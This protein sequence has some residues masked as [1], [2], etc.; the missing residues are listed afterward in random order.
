MVGQQALTSDGMLSVP[1]VVC[2][3]FNTRLHSRLRAE[4]PGQT[5]GPAYGLGHTGKTKGRVL[6]MQLT[7]PVESVGLMRVHLAC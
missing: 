3:N 7:T 4:K 5:R 1:E 6:N 2:T